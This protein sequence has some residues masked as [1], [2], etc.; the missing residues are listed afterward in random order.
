MATQVIAR[1]RDTFQVTLPVRVVFEART[2][3]DL[4]LA[5]ATNEVQPGATEKIARVVLRLKH[6]SDDEK[7]EI[8]QRQKVA[9]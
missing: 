6:M 4:S 2:I 9:I 3:A 5:L 8:L 7:M 1:V